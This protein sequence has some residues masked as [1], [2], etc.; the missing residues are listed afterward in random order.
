MD[1]S[2]FPRVSTLSNRS[3]CVYCF[4]SF[5]NHSPLTVKPVFGIKGT[6]QMFIIS[7]MVIV[8]S[9]T[10]LTEEDEPKPEGH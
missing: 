2:T 10:L 6:L 9:P 7:Q 4:V 8:I 1:I 5:P 3:K